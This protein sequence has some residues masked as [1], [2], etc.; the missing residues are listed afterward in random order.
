MFLVQISKPK[1]T[2]T[3]MFA[4]VVKAVKSMLVMFLIPAFNCS[5]DVLVL[6]QCHVGCHGEY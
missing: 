2:L 4:D 5:N 1:S 3:C 6:L